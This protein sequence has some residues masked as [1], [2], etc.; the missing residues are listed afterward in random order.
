MSKRVSLQWGLRRARKHGQ[1]IVEPRANELQIDI[2][3]A[4]SLRKYGMQFSILKRAGITHGW[5]ERIT[6]SKRANHAHITIVM[7]R[8][9]KPLE[10]VGLQAILGSDL[11]REA[12]NWSRVT[13]KNKYPIAFFEKE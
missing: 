11:M 7:P 3:G 12:F 13:R 1:K 6:P 8:P 5:R 10:R 2:D 4:R 9:M